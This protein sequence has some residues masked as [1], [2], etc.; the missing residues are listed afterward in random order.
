S[1]VVFLGVWYFLN[2]SHRKIQNKW[3]FVNRFLERTRK[4]GNSPLIKKYG[5]VGLAMLMAVPF[6][7]IG[8]YGASSL[9]WMLG[10]RHWQALLAV[11]S[12]VAVSN[13]LV[14]LSVLGI[15]H[16]TTFIG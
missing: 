1:I 8:V 3:L 9:S 12:G 10:A 11:T 7:T 5:L 16:L 6:P 14:L 4:K 2:F 15:I 13:S